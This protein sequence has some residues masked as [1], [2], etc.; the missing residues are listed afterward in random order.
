[1]RVEYVG[2]AS[3]RARWASGEHVILSFWHDRLLILPVISEGV[4]MC[5]MVSQHRDGEVATRLLA[6]WRIATVRGSATR[7]AVGGF[8]RLVDA[9]RNGRSLAVLPDGPR[10]PR[11]VAKPGVVHLAK[12]TGAPIYPMAY[13]ASRAWRLK[14][15]DRLVV[16]K[17]FARLRIEIGVP[18]SVPHDAPPELLAGLRAEVETRLN[19][20]STSAEAY[21]PAAR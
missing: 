8:L 3:L 17:P 7:G 11:R 18:L 10:G 6:A 21:F 13:A 16:P 15:W 5:I 14:S 19:R 1:L 2:D 4:P 20:L 12:A 9:Y